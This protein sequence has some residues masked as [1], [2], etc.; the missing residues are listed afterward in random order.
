MGFPTV[1]A[2]VWAARPRSNLSF[3]SFYVDSVLPVTCNDIVT[4]NAILNGDPTGYTFEWVQMSGTPVIWLEDRDQTVVMFQQ[5]VLRDDKVFRFYL[6]KG[7]STERYKEVLVTAVPTDNYFLSQTKIYSSSSVSA[8]GSPS[9]ISY[10]LNIPVYR[11]PGSEAISDPQRAVLYNRPSGVV[12]NSSTLPVVYLLEKTSSGYVEVAQEIQTSDLANSQGLIQSMGL[13]KIYKL[14]IV[15]NN[16]IQDSEEFSL[17]SESFQTK[18]DL[19]VTEIDLISP[20]VSKQYSSSTINEVISRLLVGLNINDIEDNFNIN[21]STPMSNSVLDEVISR[22]LLSLSVDDTQDAVS[23][24]TSPF[25]S[26]S[27]IVENTSIF[28]SSLG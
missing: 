19:A 12:L 9:I 16:T 22:S 3:L 13:D 2:S 20:S 1:I 7:K 27:I 8:L 21:I 10:I 18:P 23:L 25:I 17:S 5:P 15:N 6:N 24:S 4:L 28:R 11:P 14:R 26:S